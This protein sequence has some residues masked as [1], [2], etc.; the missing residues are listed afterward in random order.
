[1]N[2]IPTLEE[3]FMI[4]EILNKAGRFGLRREVIE[5][6]ERILL[7]KKSD[8][9]FTLLDAYYFAFNDWVK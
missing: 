8:E 9:S 3:Q 7:E 1:M 6:A 2:H 4:E 5:S